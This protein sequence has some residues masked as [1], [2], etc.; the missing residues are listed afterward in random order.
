VLNDIALN[1]YIIDAVIGFSIVYKGFD[2]LSGFKRLLG[3]QP[4]AKLAVMIFGLFHG[5]GLATKIQE[6]E[7]PQE[8]L[9]ENLISFNVGVEPGQFLAL[10]I[11]FIALGFW[12]HQRS[13]IRFSTATNTLL[14]SG[15]M[16]L[17]GYQMIRFFV[18]S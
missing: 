8:G 13:I 5:F 4:N 7:I 18:N 16:M 3:Y 15:G 17:F 10:T 2:K 11:V 1:A 12:R 9:F 14:M 6:F